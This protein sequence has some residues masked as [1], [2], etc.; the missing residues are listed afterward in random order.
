MMLDWLMTLRV[1]AVWERPG[2]SKPDVRPPMPG[3]GD[4]VPDPVE[5]N[6]AGRV[7]QDA[8]TF[9]DS[10]ADRLADSHR[11]EGARALCRF[12]PEPA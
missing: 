8:G 12:E 4:A 7:T 6:R 3:L 2:A 5:Q 11:S 10:A 1:A 9:P